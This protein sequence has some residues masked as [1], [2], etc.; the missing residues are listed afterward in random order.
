MKL[1]YKQTLFCG[2]AFFGI[3]AFWQLYD[4]IVPLILK[5]DFGIGDT[6][7]GWIITLGNL[8]TMFLLPLFGGLSD[9]TRTPLGK[10]MPYILCGTLLGAAA[11]TLLPILS[12]QQN[13]PLFLVF[14][15]IA[16]VAMGMYR[17]PAVSLMPDI[18]PKPLRSK[19]NAII[20]LMGTVGALVVLIWVSLQM[21]TQYYVDC[22]LSGASVAVAGSAVTTYFCSGCQVEHLLSK[23][24]ADTFLLRL[25]H[26][27]FIPLFVFTALLMLGCLCILICTVKEKKLSYNRMRLEEQYGL[28]DAPLLKQNSKAERLPSGV[29][30]S[31]ILLLFAVSL[32]CMS[33]NAITI[34]FSKYVVWYWNLP[35]GGFANCLMVSLVAGAVA[36]IPI[37]MFSEKIGRRRMLLYSTVLMGTMFAILFC[38]RS[39]HPI[40]YGL[41]AF[42]GIAWAAFNVNAYPMVV[43]ICHGS[44]IG[45]YTGIYSVCLTSGRILSPVITGYLLAFSYQT[46]FPYAAVM[47][48]GSSALLLFVKHGDS[49]RPVIG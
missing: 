16:I 4:N 30:K 13:L 45:T 48:F 26:E 6:R 10:R 19:A 9:K 43:E 35:G 47:A 33:Y 3:C 1:N 12:E 27:S 32:C 38:F 37:G 14:L 25:E 40:V 42:V 29:R 20:N 17:S 2:F 28:S 44:E 15:L 22:T 11:L 23:E 7:A 31:L 49:E 34:A 5:F 36:N 46:L 41:F 39:Y 24:T 18:T 8:S 21:K